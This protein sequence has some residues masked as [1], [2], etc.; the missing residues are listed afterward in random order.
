MVSLLPPNGQ[1]LECVVVQGS[2]DLL[3]ERGHA[4][5]LAEVVE[6]FEAQAEVRDAGA[7]EEGHG[8]ED[9]QVADTF[10]GAG[11]SDAGVNVVTLVCADFAEGGESVGG[12]VWAAGID[13]RHEVGQ[14]E[15]VIDGDEGLGGSGAVSFESPR[16]VD[17]D[18]FILQLE[19]FFVRG[20]VQ[21]QRDAAFGRVQEL[22]ILDED[23]FPALLQ[24]DFV[25]HRVEYA[26]R[27]ELQRRPI[28]FPGIVD[29]D[30]ASA[31]KGYTPA[32]SPPV[33]LKF[34]EK[35]GEQ[36]RLAQRI[37][38]D[39]GDLVADFER[40]GSRAG[41]VN[42]KTITGIKDAHVRDASILS[43]KPL[44]GFSIRKVT[45]RED[46]GMSARR[47]RPNKRQ[48]RPIQLE[49]QR[50][51]TRMIRRGNITGTQKLVFGCSTIIV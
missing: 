26:F 47:L 51:Q 33:L 39:N 2:R 20:H 23:T 17:G 32:E 34:S 10:R 30:V 44:D 6:R 16:V 49:L 50:L 48:S 28:V 46:V 37:T 43:S 27:A 11:S 21:A 41:L 35:I 31:Q 12:A 14:G 15:G 45:E 19:I 5:D 42:E 7:I 9:E 25:G 4:G 24:Q 8:R 38:A 36:F 22:L 29:E 3:D 18:E 40:E 13:V 1:P